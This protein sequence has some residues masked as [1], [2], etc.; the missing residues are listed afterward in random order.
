MHYTDD[1]I[2]QRY[3]RSTSTKSSHILWK[4]FNGGNM[5]QNC[6][7]DELVWP[8]VLE[9]RPDII[10]ANWGLHMLW[11][12]KVQECNVP[13][14]L[15]YETF[16]LERVLDVALEAGTKLVLFKTTNLMC[17]NNRFG[18][19]P[20]Q[21]QQYH[22]QQQQRQGICRSVLLEDDRH[23]GS[24]TQHYNLTND[25]LLR[26]CDESAFEESSSKKLNLRL[27]QFVVVAKRNPKYSRL[28]IEILNDHDL[29]S[30]GYTQW[31]DGVHFQLLAFS[32][33][34]LLAHMIHCLW[35]DA[36]R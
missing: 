24:L 8:Q 17:N 29:E 32:R 31:N 15:Y 27:E 18:I 5:K 34:R 19:P 30:C 21:E 25:E 23:H 16:F 13:Q 9:H 3:N 20:M 6:R 1:F 33:L 11:R 14:N 28:T 4:G 12:P 2:F 22:Y 26:Y 10:V 36:I 7:F 35:K